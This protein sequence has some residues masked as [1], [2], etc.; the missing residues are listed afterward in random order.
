MTNCQEN[1]ESSNQTESNLEEAA[2]AEDIITPEVDDI[3]DKLDPED[4][5]QVLTR[6]E[7]FSGPIPPPHL[8]KGYAEVYP[9][10]PERF[11]E[12]LFSQSQHRKSLEITHQKR[13]LNHRLISLLFGFFLVFSF[14]ISAVILLVKGQEITGLAFLIPPL[15]TIIRGLIISTK[16]KKEKADTEDKETA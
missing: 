2:T 12:L 1:T 15:G 3:L 9:E 11:F 8:L 4:K 7:E 5:K 6:I 14:F 13:V 10:A 16:S